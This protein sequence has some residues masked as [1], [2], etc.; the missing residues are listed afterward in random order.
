M[1]PH[2]ETLE[3]ARQIAVANNYQ[4]KAAQANTQASEQQ[5]Q[6]TQ[7]QELPTLTIS[8]GYTQYSEPFIIGQITL[9]VKKLGWKQWKPNNALTFQNELLI[10]QK[11]TSKSFMSISFKD[12]PLLPM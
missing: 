3:E 10:R 2:A 5:I 9:Q 1:Q 8:G 6:A 12:C 11:R 7:G 4:I